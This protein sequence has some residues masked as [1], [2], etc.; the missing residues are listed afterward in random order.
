MITLIHQPDDPKRMGNLLVENLYGAKWTL[1]RAAVAF[2][3]NSGVKHIKAA[4]QNFLTQG[5]AKI[6]AGID[7]A[8]TSKEGLSE[9]LEALGTKGEGWVF[10][11]DEGRH[12]FHPKV[13]L[14]ENATSAECF[15][16]S[17]NLTEGGLYTNYEAFVQI[18]L[19]KGNVDDRTT[20]A[21]L[22]KILDTWT[23][24]SQGMALKLTAALIQELVD[25]GFVPME[26]LIAQVRGETEARICGGATEA[27]AK[28]PFGSK[29]VPAAPK[30][31]GISKRKVEQ[32]KAS[33]ESKA[34]SAAIQ[35]DD[36]TGFFMTLQQTD[37]GKGQKTKGTSKRSPEIFIPLAARDANPDFWGWSKLF[38]QD[39]S[40]PGKYDRSNVPMML[41]KHVVFVNMMTWPDKSDFRLRNGELREAG[42]VGDVLR[43]LKTEG[44]A[45]FDY[46]VEIVGPQSPSYAKYAAMC[47]NAVRM[48]NSMKRWGYH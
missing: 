20:L 33:Q 22:H 9:L 26:A 39:P 47:N 42:N 23:D 48:R 45:R 21:Q 1:F 41:G 34:G 29:R 15:I 18:R 7:H 32:K 16:G 11:N 2:V 19:E 12:T 3:K 37:V 43:I 6:S 28:S 31:A 14:F 40:K 36:L 24:S 46:V 38:K 17:G 30:V 35:T 27:R 25:K 13:Y 44:N 8:G 5:N 4:L 10:H